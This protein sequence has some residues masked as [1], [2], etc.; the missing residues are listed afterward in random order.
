M[1]RTFGIRGDSLDSNAAI[2]KNIKL[3]ARPKEIPED[4]IYS[5]QSS[6]RS[7]D[8][9]G[10]EKNKHAWSF[11]SSWRWGVLDTFFR[12]VVMSA[13]D[14][15]KTLRQGQENPQDLRK[16][17]KIRNHLSLLTCE[18]HS[19]NVQVLFFNKNSRISKDGLNQLCH[20]R[21]RGRVQYGSK[22]TRKGK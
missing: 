5:K 22:S 3:G 9:I 1:A 13:P 20:P 2:C 11:C 8:V 19:G 16:N 6:I 10:R 17:P 18:T 12:T 21:P 7:F 14:K 15:R 4:F